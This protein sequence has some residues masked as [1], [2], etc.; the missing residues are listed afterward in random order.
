MEKLID[1]YKKEIHNYGKYIEGQWACGIDRVSGM[2]IEVELLKRVVKDLEQLKS[3]LPT[4][5]DKVEVPEFVAEWYELNKADLSENIFLAI[6][7]ALDSNEPFYQYYDWLKTPSNKPIETLISMKDGYTVGK[8]PKVHDI[9]I[10]PKFLAD[11]VSGV[12]TFEIRKNDRGY[13]KGDILNLQEFEDGSYTGNEIEVLV[14]YIPDFPL[15]D[16]YVVMGIELVEE[17]SQ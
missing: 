6:K 3:S 1:K 15:P 4:R 13:K 11:I 10:K 5:Q 9:K 14:T 17:D 8:V 2:K 12:K 7:R 16:D